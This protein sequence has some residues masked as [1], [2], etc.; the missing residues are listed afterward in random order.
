MARGVLLG[1]DPERPWRLA[2]AGNLEPLAGLA[3]RLLA[4]AILTSLALA[5]ALAAE[6]PQAAEG[7]AVQPDRRPEIGQGVRVV[8]QGLLGEGDLGEADDRV[9]RCP[10]G[11]ARPSSPARATNSHS[12]TGSG[13]RGILLVQQALIIALIS[14]VMAYSD[15]LCLRHATAAAR[16]MPLLV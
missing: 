9:G 5:L 14:V 15:L 12:D 3:G 7:V 1:P 16:S 10:C 4:V 11:Q 6:Q 2:A 13:V 8:G